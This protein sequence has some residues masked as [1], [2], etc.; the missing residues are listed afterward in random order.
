VQWNHT[1]CLR[2]GRHWPNPSP[3]VWPPPRTHPEIRALT[4]DLLP[5][6]V[7]RRRVLWRYTVTW[8]TKP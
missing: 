8:W 3:A 7:Y 1:A 6:S 2:H 5:G 4:A